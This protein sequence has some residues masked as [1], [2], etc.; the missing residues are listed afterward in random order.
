MFEPRPEIRIPTRKV[1]ADEDMTEPDR[2]ACLSHAA[3]ERV[4][5]C[6]FEN[7][8]Q[9]MLQVIDVILHQILEGDGL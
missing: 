8:R 2:Y 5:A 1:F 9:V 6:L 3:R 4:R 7:M